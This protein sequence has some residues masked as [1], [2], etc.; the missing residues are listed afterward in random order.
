M[1]IYLETAVNASFE[2]LEHNLSSAVE[3]VKREGIYLV[4]ERRAR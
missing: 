3:R 2:L 1:L 4:V